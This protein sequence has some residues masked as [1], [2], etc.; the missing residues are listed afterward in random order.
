M[1][2]GSCESLS[3]RHLIL[4]ALIQ[5]AFNFPVLYWQTNVPIKLEKISKLNDSALSRLVFILPL[6]PL[7]YVESLSVILKQFE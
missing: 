5:K 7:M 2:V 6:K 1:I 3:Y 4:L